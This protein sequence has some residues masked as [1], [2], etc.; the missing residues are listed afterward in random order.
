[1]MAGTKLGNTDG[2]SVNIERGRKLETEL[3]Q[4]GKFVLEI[5]R[6]T[7]EV[8]T[9]E[10]PNGSTTQGKNYLLDAGFR[11][12]GTTANWYMSLIDATGFVELLAADTAASH[13]GWTEFQ[14]YDNT[15][16]PAWTKSA[17]SGGIMN[18]SAATSFTISAVGSGQAI[19]GAFIASSNTKGGGSGVLWAT[20]QFPAD[21]PIQETDVLNLTYFTQ[22][23]S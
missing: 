18:A 13:T 4:V 19:K 22:L 7:G 21:I 11:N 5:V 17:A 20:G 9:Y 2:F 8:L 3:Q 16:R 1:M 6:K 23:T 10:F 12:S 14:D 15:T